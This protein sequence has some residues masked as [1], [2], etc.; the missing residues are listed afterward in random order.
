MTVFLLGSPV[1]LYLR[2]FVN[3]HEQSTVMVHRE[4]AGYCLFP[5]RGHNVWNM[6]QTFKP[7]LHC[8]LSEKFWKMYE[9]KVS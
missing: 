4:S 5:R 7:L 2:Q 6:F 1:C 8:R 9:Y 3:M